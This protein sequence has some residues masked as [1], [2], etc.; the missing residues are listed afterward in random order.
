[1]LNPTNDEEER[2]RGFRF[3]FDEITKYFHR[4]FD[5]DIPACNDYK[6]FP[7]FVWNFLE[8][9]RDGFGETY[10][11]GPY[12][13]YYRKRSVAECRF[14]RRVLHVYDIGY[15]AC[16]RDGQL[17]G[18]SSFTSSINHQWKVHIGACNGVLYEMRITGTIGEH[19]KLEY[20]KFEH[21]HMLCIRDTSRTFSVNTVD[22]E[23]CVDDG[24]V[25]II[26]LD[27]TT[28]K[29]KEY[30]P[31][32]FPNARKEEE[33]CA[34]EMLWI[35]SATGEQV[36]RSIVWDEC[37]SPVIVMFAIAAE[38]FGMV[39]DL[40]EMIIDMSFDDHHPLYVE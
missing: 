7:E 4:V 24:D 11:N 20:T 12:Y 25:H 21:G 35:N 29:I 27:P 39:G 9:A 18:I 38:K 10:N 32:G 2:K 17:H 40:A 3:V 28:R 15:F 16:N 6:P 26:Q 19:G 22:E 5:E 23:L 34:A 36:P 33:E 1:M 30:K 14:T 37:V 8:H 13:D 31:F